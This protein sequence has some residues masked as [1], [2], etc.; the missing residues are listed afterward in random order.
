MFTDVNKTWPNYLPKGDYTVRTGSPALA[1]GFKN[2]PMDSFGVMPVVY[3]PDPSVSVSRTVRVTPDNLFNVRYIAGRL[4][5][6][7]PESYTITLTNALGRAVEVFAGKGDASFDLAGKAIS[8]GVYY[9]VV[10]TQNA[11]RTVKLLID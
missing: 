1:L 8:G 7:E 3:P 9:A 11:K 4:I 5:V 2:F 10:R 6:V